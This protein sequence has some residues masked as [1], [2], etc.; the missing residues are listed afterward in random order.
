MKMN[1]TILTLILSFTENSMALTM[2]QRGAFV[3]SQRKVA[4]ETLSLAYH[5]P[6][7]SAAAKEIYG[8]LWGNLKTARINYPEPGGDFEYCKSAR[9]SHYGETLEGAG[10]FA[11]DGQIYLCDSE[12]RAEFRVAE[13][14]IHEIAHVVNYLDECDATKLQLSAMNHAGRAPV[15]NGYMNGCGLD[16]SFQMP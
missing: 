5:T 1:I 11:Y 15:G 12:L 13:S 2:A 7:I 8:L 4:L 14:L 3:E 10:A 9:T 6:G 16:L